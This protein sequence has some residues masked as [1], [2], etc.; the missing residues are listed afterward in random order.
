[1]LS[2]QLLELGHVGGVVDIDVEEMGFV[3]IC[4][5]CF[6]NLRARTHKMCVV[7]VVGVFCLLQCG[8]FKW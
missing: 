5:E 7:A 3:T 1:M 2:L 6:L 4:L 8:P